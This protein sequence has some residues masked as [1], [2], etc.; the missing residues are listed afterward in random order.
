MGVRTFDLE[1]PPVSLDRP[2]HLPVAVTVHN[3]VSGP[4]WHKL[5]AGPRAFF[6]FQERPPPDA[7]CS[8]FNCGRLHRQPTGEATDSE[9]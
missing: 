6:T 1:E 8:S 7:D 5:G 4:G 2:P 9:G 3:K